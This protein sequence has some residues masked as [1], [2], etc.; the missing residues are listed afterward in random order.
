MLI[1][2]QQ[3][4]FFTGSSNLNGRLEMPN[5]QKSHSGS[6][7][8]QAIDY[9]GKQGCTEAAYLQ[10]NPRSK[11]ALYFQR[12]MQFDKNIGQKLK[13]FFWDLK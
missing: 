9:P 1:F 10:V 13:F 3:V 11:T 8:C 4:I 6:Y 7:I 12:V 2:Y 5:I